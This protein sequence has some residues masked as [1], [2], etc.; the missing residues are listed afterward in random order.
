MIAHM[1]AAMDGAVH[2]EK[3][4]GLALLGAIGAEDGDKGAWLAAGVAGA[5]VD[6]DVALGAFDDSAYADKD[7][8]F[9]SAF[10]LAYVEKCV[11][12]R[13]SALRMQGASRLP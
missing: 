6:N 8:G 5:H 4:V 2:A 3:S 11:W 10:V 9:L 7:V 13:P 12:L 1:C